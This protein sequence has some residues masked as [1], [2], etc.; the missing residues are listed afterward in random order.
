MVDQTYFFAISLLIIF[1]QRCVSWNWNTDMR[2]LFKNS[3]LNRANSKQ[4]LLINKENE[5]ALNL[6][7]NNI[8]NDKSLF[9]AASSSQRKKRLSLNNVVGCWQ[10]GAIKGQPSWQK[11]S[12]LLTILKPENIQNRNFQF[13]SINGNFSNLSEYWGTDVFAYTEGTFSPILSRESNA[14]NLKLKASVNRIVLSIFGLSI[15]IKVSGSGI[16]NVLYADEE[17]RVVES[18]EGAQVLQVKV[19]FPQEYSKYSSLNAIAQSITNNS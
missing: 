2:N 19:S 7:L 15:R 3:D 1:A 12:K 4:S 6:L 11:Y 18:E 8:V 17:K 14:P 5:P 13:F 10:V 9:A 16:V